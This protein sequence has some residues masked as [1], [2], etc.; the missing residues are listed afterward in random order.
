MQLVENE[1]D[2]LIS[3]RVR[4]S[5]TRR[6]LKNIQRH[7][8]RSMQEIQRDHVNVPGS[9]C[10]HADTLHDPLDREKTINALVIDLRNPRGR[11]PARSVETCR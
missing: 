3:T 11:N 2:E 10:S 1:P 7:T 5:R 4:N 8:V 6:L 9:I